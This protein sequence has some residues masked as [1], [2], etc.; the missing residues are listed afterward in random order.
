[1]NN[2][3]TNRFRSNLGRRHH[4]RVALQLP[5]AP[6]LAT[7][8]DTCATGNGLEEYRTRHK[9]ALPMR[10]VLCLS[11]LPNTQTQLP[12]RYFHAPDAS[13]NLFRVP[14]QTLWDRVYIAVTSGKLLAAQSRR[15]SRWPESLESRL[16][17]HWKIPY[18]DDLR[19]A[20]LS[21]YRSR[22]WTLRH[23]RYV[24]Q[25]HCAPAK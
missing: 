11:P 15:R 6:S 4:R 16:R 9:R 17:G 13:Q 7:W 12:A 3:Y 14:T 8:P 24:R 23:Y 19:W 10:K 18:I 25:S 5:A 20:S 2:P 21:S 1:M 22:T